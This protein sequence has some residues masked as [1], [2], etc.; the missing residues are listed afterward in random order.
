MIAA[1]GPSRVLKGCKQGKEHSPQKDQVTDAQFLL[2][3]A[4]LAILKNNWDLVM[5]Q[6]LS[7]A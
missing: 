2:Y 1:S 4:Q 5:E 6:A 3:T 7:W